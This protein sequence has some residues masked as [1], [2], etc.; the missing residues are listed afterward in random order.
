[1]HA[2]APKPRF[3]VYFQ[4]PLLAPRRNSDLQVGGLLVSALGND[5]Y[6]KETEQ[7]MG[8][9]EKLSCNA[10]ITGPSHPSSVGG[11]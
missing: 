4:G 3:K 11:S 6:G 9:N 2:P 7:G 8:Q 1:M 5:S 10:T